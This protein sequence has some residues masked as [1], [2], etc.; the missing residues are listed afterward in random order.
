MSE[1][2]FNKP[3]KTP[4]LRLSIHSSNTELMLTGFNAYIAGQDVL[5]MLEK[6]FKLERPVTGAKTMRKRVKVAIEIIEVHDDTKI[7]GVDQ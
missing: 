2:G 1:I 6:A 7:E 4:P 3:C 5:L